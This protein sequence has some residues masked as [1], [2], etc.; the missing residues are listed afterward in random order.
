[1][2]LSIHFFGTELYQNERKKMWSLHFSVDNFGISRS[3]KICLYWKAK[4]NR[5]AN[6]LSITID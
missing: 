2:F 3:T 1:M 6:I 4:K 5:E